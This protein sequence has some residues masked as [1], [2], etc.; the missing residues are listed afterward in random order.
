VVTGIQRITQQRWVIRPTFLRVVYRG[1]DVVTSVSRTG[2]V[3]FGLGGTRTHL[4]A[5]HPHHPSPAATELAIAIRKLNIQSG[6]CKPEF[7]QLLE[8]WLQAPLSAG[9]LRTVSD[10]ETRTVPE[11][12]ETIIRRTFFSHTRSA[13][14]IARSRSFTLQVYA[15]AS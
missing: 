12:R 4:S 14:V 3:W 11:V 5:F 10:L 2:L 8:S 15:I 13:M 6:P 9:H 1:V 7:L